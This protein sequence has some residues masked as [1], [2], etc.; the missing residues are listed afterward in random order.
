MNFTYDGNGNTHTI[1]NGSTLWTYNYD[2]NNRL[3]SVEDNSVTVAT[4]S[5]DGSGMLV[6][7][8]E[9]DTETYAYN[10]GNRIYAKNTGTGSV[11]DYFYGDGMILA[12]ANG[13]T[14]DYFHEDALGSVRLETSSSEATLFSADYRPY[15]PTYGA[16]ASVAFG[17]TGKPTD[18]ATGL[19]YSG[20]RFYDPA[21]GRFMTQDSSTGSQTAPLTLNR[22]IYACDDP[23]SVVDPTGHFG[24]P[25]PDMAKGNESEPD[26]RDHQLVER[27]AACGQGRHCRSGG[28]S[29]GRS[30]MRSRRCRG[31]RVGSICSD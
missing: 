17:Y 20:A 8:V 22:Y 24:M 5:Y 2:Y 26:H 12:S 16:T 21:S 19:Y 29:G 28:G 13:T 1:D 9:K 3:T 14:T 27:T 23:M 6:H 10:A 30:N 25:P 7:S 15:G 18:A 31:R 4:Y 11:V